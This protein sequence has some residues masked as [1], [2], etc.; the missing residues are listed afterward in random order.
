M[1]W[2]VLIFLGRFIPYVGSLVA[3]TI[4]ILLAFLD[5]QP[6]WKPCVVTLLL[7]PD[8]HG[9]GLRRRADPDAGKAVDLS[10]LAALL[11]VAFW[12]LCWGLTGML[13][14][15]PLTA[16]LKI[17]CENMASTRPLAVLMAE[18]DG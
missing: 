13:L 18:G 5:L 14:A 1:L 2:G 16:M 17:V 8:R 15:V 9:N 10:P 3:L 4:P 12:S 7:D 11:C 6:A